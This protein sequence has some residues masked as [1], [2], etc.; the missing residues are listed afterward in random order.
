MNK[1]IKLSKNEKIKEKNH[2][3]YKTYVDSPIGLLLLRAT[4]KK[5]I[6]IE[7]VEY[8]SYEVK[9]NSVLKKTINQL[10]EYFNGSRLT[11]EIPI[12]LNGTDF[13]KKVWKELQLIKYGKTC[14]YKEIAIRVNN[15]KASRAIGNA[16]NKNKIPI[17]IPCHRV[18]GSNG[19]LTG[20]AGG[21]NIKK[22][23][24]DHEKEVLERKKI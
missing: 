19:K 15:P 24:L 6:S 22:W 4:E 3:E 16:N 5:L 8:K 12:E 7:F 14:A 2:N 21:V 11:F 13:Q 9:E 10:K 17:I 18:I 23:L 1:K 20:Y